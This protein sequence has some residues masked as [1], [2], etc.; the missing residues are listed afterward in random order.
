MTP[1]QSASLSESVLTA[2]SD[3]AAR[4]IMPRYT[5]LAAG[6]VRSKTHPGDLVTVADEEAE[7]ELTRIFG[8]L[9]PGSICVGEEAVA[10]TP[11]LI[12]SL[13]SDAPVWIIDPIDG[14]AN[15]V[16]GRPRFAVM[17]A[18]VRGGQTVLGWIHDPV[19]GNSLWAEQGAGTWLQTD[20]NTRR[21]TIRPQDGKPLS[22]MIA[23][24]HHPD[25]NLFKG[26][27]ARITRLGSAAHDYW[28]MADGR[29]QVLCYRRIKPWDHAAGVLIHAEA[30]G[31]NRL[32]SG[33]PYNPCIRDQTGLLCAPNPEIWEHV[34]GFRN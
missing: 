16:N 12:E 29:M 33:E 15:F 24:L 25:F 2:M 13:R 1:L 23:E 10:S 20:S 18:L 7:Q 22:D 21:L 14:T 28:A 26:K 9:L 3:V 32:L 31:Y 8:D 27:F 30:G 19:S 34:A 17:V 4:I 6:D 11:E 5:K